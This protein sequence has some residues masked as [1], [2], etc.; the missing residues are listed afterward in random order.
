MLFLGI[1]TS[2]YA[3][4]LGAYSPEHGIVWHDKRFLPVAKGSLGLRQ[5]D[6][7]FEHVRALPSMIE[8]LALEIDMGEIEG[9][10]FSERP[11]DIE[12]S[13]MPCFLA[14]K[15]IGISIGA[16]LGVQ[17]TGFSHQT[18]HIAAALFGTPLYADGARE[19]IAFH[20]SGGTTDA[21]SC[22][23]EGRKIQ[24]T[25]LATSLDAHA[26]QI[27]DRVG[28]S[29]GLGFPAGAELSVLAMQSES[30]EFASPVLKGADCCFSG[31]ENQCQALARR[32][33]SECDIAR[34]CLLSVAKTICAMT[35]ALKP[36]D[37]PVIYAGG[38]M[39]SN[40]VR[41][42]LLCETKHAFFSEPAWL[43]ADNAAGVAILASEAVL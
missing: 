11:R 33:M 18:G 5:S 38:V 15:A 26:G 39:Q 16:S 41:E 21:V 1:D 35:Q 20:V 14:G 40:L 25:Q 32:G 17:T 42:T 23:I 8:K 9:V 13:Y 24:I 30:A 43:S 6:A 22:R 29:L 36:G 7:V 3:T 4:S 12:N 37:M 31:L 34:F 28:V 27:I 10:G 2:N 19:F